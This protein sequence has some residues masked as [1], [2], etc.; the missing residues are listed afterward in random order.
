M[1]GRSASRK[2]SPARPGRA[3][4]AAELPNWGWPGA[5]FA[6]A[7]L[8]LPQPRFRRVRRPR[9][10]GFR[11]SPIR[12]A[13]SGAA[14]RA[15]RVIGAG[16]RRSGASAPRNTK[17]VNSVAERSARIRLASPRDSPRCARGARRAQR[18]ARQ[19]TSI[20]ARRRC[21]AQ[22]TGGR[23]RR[24]SM[25]ARQRIDARAVTRVDRASCQ[26]GRRAR[27][28]PRSSIR[29]HRQRAR[30]RIP[31]VQNERAWL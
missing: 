28:T 25:H 24:A 7:S 16:P 13:R 1:G 26:H 19:R 31:F 14:G 23:A 21:T 3:K 10:C 12:R 11:L 9:R 15:D 5:C 8:P 22:R 17:G 29:L 27:C 4:Y 6:A 30:A 20:P 18:P 2:Q